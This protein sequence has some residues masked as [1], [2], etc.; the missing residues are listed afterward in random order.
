MTNDFQ[1]TTPVAF[2]V[3]NR[4]DTTQQVFE[5]IRRARPPKLLVVA[6]GPRVDRPEEEEK[7]QAVRAIIDTVD[8]PCEILKNYSDVNLGCKMRV[9]SGLDWV[10]EQVEEAIVLEDDCLPDPTFFRFCE[11]LLEK[12]RHDERIFMI[13][14]A[15]FQFSQKR[16]NASYY[17]TRYNHIWGWA[18]W[19]RAWK[20]YDRDIKLW[21]TI[22]AEE[23]LKSVIPN[24]RECRFW[25][26]I[27]Q[28]VYEGKIDTWDYQV[29]FASYIN[30][31]VSIIPSAN[32]I[33]NI[34]FG[35]DATHT[36]GVTPYANMLV[37]PMPFPLTHPEL[38]LTHYKAD[39]FTVKTMFMPS[40]GRRI[41]RKFRFVMNRLRIGS[42]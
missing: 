42:N 39:N 27:F 29:N 41:L 38:F 40:V 30:N 25:S 20:H 24:Q 19:R 10:F 5:A 16:T 22:N 28:T 37:S 31:M 18:S 35:S 11:E 6:D 1:L 15:N 26:D 2:L 3:F 8:W 13:C 32:M 21:P 23:W 36:Q 7:C 12:Y 14:G 34:G 9:S 33:S 4:P 17:F